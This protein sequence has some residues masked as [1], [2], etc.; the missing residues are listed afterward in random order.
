MKIIMMLFIL[1]MPCIMQ[2]Q[3]KKDS[4]KLRSELSARGADFS[5][6]IDTSMWVTS[7]RTAWSWPNAI[8][9]VFRANSG[10]EFRLTFDGDSLK[11]SGTLSLDNAATLFM[12]NVVEQYSERIKQL[13]EENAMLQQKQLKDLN[14]RKIEQ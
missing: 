11:S 2:P 14:G 1:N 8:N 12:Q 5:T 3:N 13:K 7:L 10:K 6:R 9:I 4:L